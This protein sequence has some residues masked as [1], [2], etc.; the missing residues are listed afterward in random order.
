VRVAVLANPAAGRGRSAACRDA[1]L[2]RF[3]EHGLDAVALAATSAGDALA[4]ANEAAAGG[5]A[6]VAVG[7]DGTVHLALQAAA[8]HGAPLGIVPAGTGNDFAAAVGVP[9]DPLAAADAIGAALASGSRRALDAVRASGPSGPL[10]WWSTVFCAGFDAAVNA[11]ANA[12]RWPRGPRR[13]DLAILAELSRLRPYA[14]TL[15]LDGERWEGPAILVAI[16]NT[17]SYGG[18]MKMCP[19]ADPADGL[20]DVTIAGPMSRAMLVRLKPRLYDGSHV[21]HPL[22]TTLRARTVTVSA[23][24]AV[25]YADGEPLA[26]LPV[27]AELVPG[28]LSL[29]LEPA[30]ASE[31]R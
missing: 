23:P 7:G 4:A 15:D 13:Y 24:G 28:A 14:F 18:G 9:A 25:S 1:V 27:T 19:A 11:R 21:R 10:N 22:V 20:L 30:S 5:A 16:G 29:L 6:L 17:R 2:R 31:M 3:A 26:P 8:A 12:M